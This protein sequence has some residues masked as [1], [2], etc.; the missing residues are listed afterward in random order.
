MMQLKF[1][2]VGC[3]DAIIVKFLGDDNAIHNIII[4]G[5]PENAQLY[6]QT[7]HKEIIDILN[8]G[9]KIDLWIITHIDND[10]IGGLLCLINDKSLLNLIDLSETVFLYN[11]N[12]KD[13]Y[14][15][16]KRIDNF[17][18]VSQGI[19][20]RDFLL[21]KSTVLNNI[22]AGK[23]I[24]SHGLDITIIS[25]SVDIYNELQSK[26]DHEEIKITKDSYSHLIS[27]PKSDFQ[28]PID[29]FDPNYYEEDNNTLWNKS[30]I[31]VLIEH[32]DKRILLSADSISSVLISSLKSMGYSTN[33]KIS[34]DCFQLPHHGSKYNTSKE[35]LDMINCDKYV[36]CAN[37]INKHKL[38]NK[39]TIARVISS[40]QKEINFYFTDSNSTLSSIFFVDD[41]NIVSSCN[42]HFPVN[43]AITLNF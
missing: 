43:N 4:D 18:S 28:I 27:N 25:P 2:N 37:A 29:S 6:Q 40:N 12:Y 3:A 17:I 1:L 41:Q 9:E 30:S 8:L 16:K 15:I 22:T 20:L 23:K 32:D 26:W 39:E 36:I 10:H 42:M 31:A 11:Y 19:R 13:D 24:K 35:L 7:L 14:L 34:L 5:G 21:S 38:P 33:N